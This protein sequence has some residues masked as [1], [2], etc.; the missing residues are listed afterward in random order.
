MISAALVATI[1]RG[2]VAGI[3][4]SIVGARSAFRVVID[5]KN[6]RRTRLQEARRQCERL[7]R[8]TRS[9]ESSF[10]L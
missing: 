6:A 2:V 4:Y 5:V 9:E 8:S 3:P 7:S 1:N 10:S